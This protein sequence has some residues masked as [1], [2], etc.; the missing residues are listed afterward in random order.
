MPTRAILW[1]LDGV[2]VNSME[3]HYQAFQEVLARRARELSRE[4]YLQTI[5]GLRNDDIFRKLLGDLSGEEVRNLA[6]RKEEVF[7]RLISGRVEAL[8]GAVELVGR[9]KESGL[10]QAIVSSTPREN[11]NVIL[12]SLHV[13]HEF[14]AIVGEEDVSR[15]KPDPEGFALAAKRVDVS[16]GECIVIEDAPE[17]LAAGKAAGM[18]CIGVATTRHPG[19]LGD[20]DLVVESVEDDR[21]WEFISG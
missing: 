2:L 7:R 15:G 16:A 13:A 8:P 6:N 3:F 19:Q 17:G 11:I 1:D 12:S 21:V 18:R 10:R 5:I 4:E 14:D 20:A 9:A